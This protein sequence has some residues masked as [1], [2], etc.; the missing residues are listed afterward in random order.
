MSDFEVLV[1]CDAFVGF[2]FSNDAHHSACY[3]IFEQFSKDHTNLATTN[4]TIAET[5]TVLSRHSGQPLARSFLDY[6]ETGVFPI[7]YV[8]E[9][10]QAQAISIFRDVEN[11]KTSLFDCANV[12]VMR[13]FGISKI[14][15]F[16]HIYSKR[17]HLPTVQ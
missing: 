2:F 14:F 4:Y 7:I 12:A 1:D 5:A 8:D 13:K 17:F 10:I 11:K 16:D 6:V 9:M 15:S 3:T